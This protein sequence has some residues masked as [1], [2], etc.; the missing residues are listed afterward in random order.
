MSYL[1]P[2]IFFLAPALLTLS[3]Q[4]GSAFGARAAANTASGLPGVNA[5]FDYVIVGGGTAGL[6]L[7]SRLARDQSLSVAV[8]EA[9]GYYEADNGNLS[10]VPGYCTAY[11]G[12]D[13]SLT[14][15]RD[16]WGFVTVPQAVSTESV[17]LPPAIVHTMLGCKRQEAALRSRQDPW[18]LVSN[19]LY[20]LSPAD[21][22][23]R[24]EVGIG[25]W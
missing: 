3:A 16:D 11:A 14:N 7:A 1:S 10:V 13:P 17:V 23:I 9:G 6:T 2:L 25:D 22:R 20:V 21:G 18:R 5:T 8:V 24:P 12:T 4:K 15:P 19:K